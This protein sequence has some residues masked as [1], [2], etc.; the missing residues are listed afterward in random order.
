[1]ST[2]T[3]AYEGFQGSVEVSLEDNC[4]YGR[5]LHIEDLVTY[6]GGSPEELNKAFED[7]IRDYLAFCEEQGK[8]PNKPFKGSLNVRLGPELHEKAARKAASTGISLNDFIR[9]AVSAHLDGPAPV[10]EIHNHNHEHT[11]YMVSATGIAEDY[12]YI[13]DSGFVQCQEQS[14]RLQLKKSQP[15]TPRRH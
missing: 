2:H 4:L 12:G 15:T 14:L 10:Q 3:L 6:E 13:N 1:M 5:V 11:H 8:A 7:A 9:D